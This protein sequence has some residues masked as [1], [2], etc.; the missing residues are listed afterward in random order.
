LLNV[1]VNSINLNLDIQKP[2][3]KLNKITGNYTLTSTRANFTTKI[4]L[5]AV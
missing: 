4:S 2:E 5:D 3:L 1:Y